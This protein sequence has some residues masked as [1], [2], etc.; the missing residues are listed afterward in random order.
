M[1][2]AG[3]H[4]TSEVAMPCHCPSVVSALGL[5]SWG[6]KRAAQLYMQEQGMREAMAPHLRI[7]M[8]TPI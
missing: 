6:G 5:T 7:P 2:R 8:S 3:L 4:L 1:Q